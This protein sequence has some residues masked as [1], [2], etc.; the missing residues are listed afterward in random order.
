MKIIKKNIY[1]ILNESRVYLESN[2]FFR[3]FPAD[4][5]KD[6]YIVT[7]IRYRQRFDDSNNQIKFKLLEQIFSKYEK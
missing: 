4:I 7:S 1:L 3:K 5:T 6:L 2:P